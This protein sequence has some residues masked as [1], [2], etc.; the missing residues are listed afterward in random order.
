M[1]N[2]IL[3]CCVLFLTSLAFSA[4]PP[5]VPAG[6]WSFQQSYQVTNLRMAEVVPSP[7]NKPSD[8]VV[9]LRQ[10]GFQCIHQ[11]RQINGDTRTIF[12]CLS[13]KYL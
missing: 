10:S 3:L 1:K 7:G 9:E 6:A 8:R 4:L 13:Q 12:K 5:L 2:R 11:R